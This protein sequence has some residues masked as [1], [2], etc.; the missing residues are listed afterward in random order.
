MRYVTSIERLGIE[1]GIQ[2]GMQQGMQQGR[3]QGMAQLLVR[4]LALR[5]GDV[6]ASIRT[7]LEAATDDEL[8][9]WAD[10]VVSAPSLEAVFARVRN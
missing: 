1:K 4:Q 9:S 6:P 7:K 3:H 8:E 10:A 2:Q 5:F